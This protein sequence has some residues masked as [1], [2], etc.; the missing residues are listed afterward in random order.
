LE[1]GSKKYLYEILELKSD[2]FLNVNW[3]VTLCGLAGDYNQQPT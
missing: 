1:E 2:A 3:I